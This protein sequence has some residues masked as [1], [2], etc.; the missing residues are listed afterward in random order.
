MAQHRSKNKKYALIGGLVVLTLA[1]LIGYRWYSTQH[2]QDDV[3]TIG[4]S[5]PYAELLQTVAEEVK[6][7]GI[8]V[9]L[10][11]FSD[12]NAPNVAVQNGDIDANFFQ[13]S[14]FLRNAIQETGYDLK[15]FAIGTGSHVGLY[16]KKYK[17][18]Q[19][20]PQSASVVIPSDPV[21]L[22]RALTLLQRA[23]LISLKDN[24]QN[25]LLTTQD[26][27]SNPKQ[28]RFL[29]VEGPQTARAYNEAD[30]IF[31]FPHYLNMAKVADPHDA[32]FLDP[33]DKKYAILFVTRND[34][35]DKN[36]K[37][38]KFVT[39]FQ[40]SKSARAIL[41]KDFGQGL[42]FEGWK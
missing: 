19:A 26:I 8:Q 27:V 15:S 16:S 1:V 37:L 13:Q 3:L 23:K 30:L 34:Y 31:G 42:W 24:A 14:V 2:Q 41:D 21:N 11:E 35:Q 40:N 29:E 36:Q 4:I 20:L 25:D 9:K 38:E 33:I 17:S 32:L 6:Q 22:S 18:L 7:Q 39:A 12:W 5:P 10:I 28:L